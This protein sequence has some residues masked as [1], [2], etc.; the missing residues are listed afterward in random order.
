MEE[1]LVLTSLLWMSS[2]NLGAEANE[3]VFSF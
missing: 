2:D 3:G 1:G